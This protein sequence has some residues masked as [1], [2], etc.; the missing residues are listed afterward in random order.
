VTGFA[1]DCCCEAAPL[2]LLLLLHDTAG[3]AE[4]F[5]VDES[6]GC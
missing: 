3:R 4:F 5:K 1:D 2:P 6:S